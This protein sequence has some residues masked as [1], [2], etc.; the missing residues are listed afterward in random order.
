M[1]HTTEIINRVLPILFL[2]FLGQWIRRRNFLAESTIEDLRKIAVN[3]ALP[4]VLFTSFLQIQ[5]KSAYFVI[6][7]LIFILCVG[8]FG[9]GQWLRRRL[10]LPYTY[11][12]FLMTGFEYGMLGISLFGSAYGLEKIGYLAIVDLGHEIFIWF[13]FLALLLIKRDG[14]QKPTELVQAFFK[15]PVIL[16]I[17]AGIILNLLGA[18]Q[19]LY[20][21]PITGALMTTLQFLGNLT[22]PIILIIV[23]YGIKLDRYGIKEAL[24]VVAIR[25]VILIPTALILNTFII[26]ELLQLEKPFAAALFTLLILPPPFIIPLYMRTDLVQEKRYINNV[27]TLYTVISIAIYTVYFILNPQI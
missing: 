9:L 15:S 18:K 22:I 27:L 1:D 7:G 3:L 21:L 14:L 5:L 12:P 25:L 24:L 23:G 17:L 6:F 11:F 13:V 8:M 10:N 20:Q 16:A 26:G 4:A 2:I 19:A